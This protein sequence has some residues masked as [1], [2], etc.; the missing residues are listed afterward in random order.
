MPMTSGRLTANRLPL[1]FKVNIFIYHCG[2]KLY[3]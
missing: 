2:V 1:A 3:N